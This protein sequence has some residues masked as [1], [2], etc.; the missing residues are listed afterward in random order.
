MRMVNGAL[1]MNGAQPMNG[2]ANEEKKRNK[3][4]LKQK[5]KSPILCHSHNVHT[6]S[7]LLDREN[8]SSLILFSRHV[9]VKKKIF[10]K[11]FF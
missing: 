6:E 10:F 5:A 9:K 11:L 3:K 2:A 1:A 4:V 7:A 8:I